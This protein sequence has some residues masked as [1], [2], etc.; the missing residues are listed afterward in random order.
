[1]KTLLLVVSFILFCPITFGQEKAH[2]F[3]E[4][5]KK[6]IRKYN[7]SCNAAYEKGDLKKGQLLFDSLVQNYLIGT[8]IDNYSLKCANGKKV[9]LGKTNQPVFII[10][11]SSWCVLNKAEIQ[12]LNKLSRK[13]KKD[14]QLIVLF[15]DTKNNIKKLANR[16]DN[17]IKVC[18]ANEKY[19][20]DEQLVSNLKHYLG[21]PTSYFLDKDLKIID[22][23]KGNPQVALKTSFA[24][25]LDF[26]MKFFQE[27][28]SNFIIKKD[29]V[30]HPYAKN[31]N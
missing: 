30:T 5:I 23:Q 12:A 3:S 22:I 24:K 21:F 1:M 15:W 11:Y 27:R 26:N 28:I 8:K 25:T 13:Y 7:Q 9:K 20:S 29:N 17:D 4:E 18:Y 31:G 10:T 6:H 14:F 2:S 16:F 19:P